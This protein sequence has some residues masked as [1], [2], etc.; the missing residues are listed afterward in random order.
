MIYGYKL[1]KNSEYLD[2]RKS[3]NTSRSHLY[4]ITV[5][6]RQKIKSNEW[7]NEHFREPGMPFEGL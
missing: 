4:G 7:I 5:S 1:V 3:T 6:Y 2:M